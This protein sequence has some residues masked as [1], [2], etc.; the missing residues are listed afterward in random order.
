MDGVA[1]PRESFQPAALLAALDTRRQTDGI[2]WRELARRA[3][4]PGSYGIAGKLRHGAH[5]TAGVLVLLLG[6]L[7]E[8]DLTPYT[9]GG[10][11]QDPA[12]PAA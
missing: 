10:A 9:T 7:G 5:P 4:I 2:S 3:G 12:A 1:A 8:K 6:Y 11:G